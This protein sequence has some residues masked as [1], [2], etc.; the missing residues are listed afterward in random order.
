MLRDVL[1]A[2]AHF[3]YWKTEY[4]GFVW[5]LHNQTTDKIVDLSRDNLTYNGRQWATNTLLDELLPDF[6]T[7][8][9][10][11]FQD[12]INRKK[13]DLCNIKIQYF[14]YCLTAL[15]CQTKSYDFSLLKRIELPKYI[16]SCNKKSV[17]ADKLFNDQ[18]LYL[19]KGF[20]TNG[21]NIIITEDQ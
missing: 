15:A 7:L 14:N 1:V 5:N 18:S 10:E 6:L 8:I 19:I 3:N 9:R 12:E 13:S 2:N 17:K 4:M 21:N 20:K 11:E 16:V